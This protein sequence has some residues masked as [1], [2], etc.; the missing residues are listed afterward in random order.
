MPVGA[1][2]VPSGAKTV[3]KI[4]VTTA[5]G[6]AVAKKGSVS[7]AYPANAKDA[8][9]IAAQ[10]FMVELTGKGAS[11]GF[12]VKDTGNALVVSDG[13]SGIIVTQA[14]AGEAE[15][16]AIKI[17][18]KAKNKKGKKL[19][20]PFA[21]T[22]DEDK[23][24][25]AVESVEA[26]I[27]KDTIEVGETAEVTYT[28]KPE[29]VALGADFESDN[30][31]VATVDGKGIVT[32]VGAG[33]ATIS[34]TVG[35]ATGTVDVTVVAEPEPSELV[36]VS[37][38]NTTPKVGDTCNAILDPANFEGAT[39][40]WYTS[41]SADESA[42][43][44]EIEGATSSSL[45]ITN[46]FVGK[47]IMVVAS[48]GTEEGIFSAVTTAKVSVDSSS[49]VSLNDD[50]GLQ[51]DGTA[52]IGDRLT[53][54]YGS[55]FGIPQN[56]TW[57]KDGKVVQTNSVGDTVNNG[58]SVTITDSKW[59]AGVY[60][61]SIT[62]TE[63][64]ATESN[65]II[66]TD[67]ETPAVIGSFV[68][69]DVYD[70]ETDKL[71]YAKTD[72]T[73]VATVTL[74][75]AYNGTLEIY[76]KTDTKFTNKIDSITAPAPSTTT[77]SLTPNKKVT[78]SGCLYIAPDGTANYK[79]V[80][81]A[82]L[83]RG[84]EYVLAFDQQQITT[85]KPG[86]GTANVTAEATVAPYL[87]TPATI[88]I[89]SVAKGIAPEVS[90][91][92][93]DGAVLGWLAA[94]NA[95][96]TVA[97]LQ[98]SDVQVYGVTANQTTG[99]TSLGVTT[100]SKVVKGVMTADKT[101]GNTAYFY[102]TAK[103]VAGVY[104]KDA[105]TIT[106]DAA[107]VAANAADNIDLIED[108]TDATSAK[109]SFK[110]LRTE[111]KVYI[112]EGAVNGLTVIST[113]ADIYTKIF[114]VSAASA[115][116]SADVAKG[117]A[118]VVVPNAI[119]PF[120]S[121]AAEN[122]YI[123]VFVPTDKTS[124]AEVY[125]DSSVNFNTNTEA[126]KAAN[127]GDTNESL[128]ITQDPTDW[129]IDGSTGD[130]VKNTGTFKVA[131]KDQFGQ[132]ITTI[133]NGIFN[134]D[135]LKEA[136]EKTAPFNGKADIVDAGFTA[137]ISNTGNVFTLAATGAPSTKGA[138]YF[139]ALPGSK[140]QYLYATCATAGAVGTAEFKITIG[141]DKPGDGATTATY[142]PAFNSF[143]N[144][145][146]TVKAD[147]LTFKSNPLDQKDIAFAIV[148]KAKTAMNTD[149]GVA[150]ELEV[151]VATDGTLTFSNT[152]T[153]GIAAGTYYLGYTDGTNGNFGITA[154]VTSAVTGTNA[155]TAAN[156]GTVS[157]AAYTPD[158]TKVQTVAAG[159]AFTNGTTAL[160]LVDQFGKA[161]TPAADLTPNVTSVDDD[162]TGLV[163][164]ST[165]SIDKTTKKVTFTADSGTQAAG[166]T[167]AF[168]V[169]D[170]TVTLTATGAS[171]WTYGVN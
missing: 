54:T 67:K 16:S 22:F 11:K 56:I 34:V 82:G 109:V 115:T 171:A 157:I 14:T 134:A 51:A 42:A 12:K 139:I 101:A 9:Y 125:T 2:V 113:P 105:V 87:E 98:F 36:G 78:N 80:V 65:E 152:K 75:K 148:G 163:G 107:S 79:F 95:G 91:Y 116:A 5:E 81:D 21:V 132:A 168:D 154:T 104:G 146:G 49:D 127:A 121:T 6:Q 60:K 45:K 169:A 165:V 15:K 89:T 88:A 85:D 52:V 120:S 59:G 106:S 72:V 74:G 33:K 61:V 142:T 149:E 48:D 47:F 55:S 44:T 38:D 97:Q 66:V 130:A 93:K 138:G 39:Y 64:K 131:V 110:N 123:A 8:G 3:K 20:F 160:V 35:E 57:Y 40:V 24:W 159:S 114:Q 129:A 164:D 25:I 32:G 73:A 96:K 128:I 108:T 158:L 99:G 166:D 117:A 124:F 18:S 31:A 41:D 13:E 28:V 118:S 150:S 90:F 30:E 141:T 46:S 4:A 92:D 76:E 10:A 69:E 162:G 145:S 151:T 23:E 135:L 100:A 84:K 153:T 86:V 102:A 37:I 170:K 137:A 19:K 119:K 136:D 17:T 26:V 83:T 126:C 167:F 147:D 77:A 94:D 63:G 58:L 111:G 156:L 122:R 143:G 112:V 68:L 161:F 29:G 50:Y 7:V 71:T 43:W 62:N 1:A 70:G 53:V 27:D 140:K 133:E 155:I 144:P 103:T